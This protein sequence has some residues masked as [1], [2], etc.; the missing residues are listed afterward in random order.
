MPL[1]TES[2]LCP[3]RL[4]LVFALVFP[5]VL[6]EENAVLLIDHIQLIEDAETKLHYWQGNVGDH[7][8][9]VAGIGQAVGY[10]Q[11]TAPVAFTRLGEHQQPEQEEGIALW[12]FAD[13]F[14]LS[15]IEQIAHDLDPSSP[16]PPRSIMGG[17]VPQ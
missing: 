16:L 15:V 6:D 17:A 2:I 11:I 10:H 3:S 12:S 8:Q 13:H 14:D 5:P 7:A 9:G 1:L 4:Q